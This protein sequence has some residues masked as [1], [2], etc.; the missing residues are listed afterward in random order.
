MSFFGMSVGYFGKDQHT[1]Y[2]SFCSF[3]SADSVH[4][5]ALHLNQPRGCLNTPLWCLMMCTSVLFYHC[6]HYTH[7]VWELLVL[8]SL[9]ETLQYEWDLSHRNKMWSIALPDDQ[10]NGEN[11]V[12]TSFGGFPVPVLD[13]IVKIP[14]GAFPNK[15]S[16]LHQNPRWPNLCRL[17]LHYSSY[18][19][20]QQVPGGKNIF[21]FA[22]HCCST[23]IFRRCL[24]YIGRH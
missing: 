19:K 10:N 14:P 4:R 11:S 3:F 9:E 21:C 5:D 13:F 16:E 24:W 1:Y 2:H 23:F 22:F 20:P 8:N 17:S 7:P 6:L 18:V 15:D 12:T